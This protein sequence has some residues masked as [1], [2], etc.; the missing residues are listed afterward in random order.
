MVLPFVVERAR[1][2]ATMH[3]PDFWMRSLCLLLG[4][5]VAPIA[6]VHWRVTGGHGGGPAAQISFVAEQTGELRV[7]PLHAFLRAADLQPG[8]SSA[9][10]GRVTVANQ[11]SRSLSVR[12]R[13]TSPA[14]D[15]DRALRI[16]VT[17]GRARVFSGNL[18]QLRRWSAGAFRLDV[19]ERRTLRVRAWLRRSARDYE[20]RAASARLQFR[21]TLTQGSRP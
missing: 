18:G 3:R 1:V 5:A 12:L 21:S 15:L 8:R 2:T 9:V 7:A 20:G 14:A 13:A 17:A 4:L 6:L 19:D 16:R 11:T 10:T